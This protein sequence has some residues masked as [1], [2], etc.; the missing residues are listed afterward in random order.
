VSAAVPTKTFCEF[1]AGIGLVAAGLRH[2]G[3]QCVYANDIDP[4]KQE[5]YFAAWG[6]Q[7]YF[8]LADV[9][10]TA[11]IVER[12]PNHPFLAAASFPCTDL[13]LAGMGKGFAGKQSGAFFGFANVLEKLGER[14]PPMV[15]LENVVGFLHASNGGDFRKAA[16]TLAALGYRFDVL[17]IDARFFTPQSRPRVFIVGVHESVLQTVEAA[18]LLETAEF[19]L[20]G[21]ESPFRPSAI[22][23]AVRSVDAT[24]SPFVTFKL[25]AIEEPS[26][27][28]IQLTDKNG[29]WWTA[30]ETDRHWKMLSDKH[31]H[32]LE[33]LRR[34]RKAFIGTAFRRIRNKEQRLE[35]RFDGM[36][37]CL[38]TPRGGSARQI[39]VEIKNGDV[40]MRWMTPTEYARLQGVPDLPLVGSASQQMFGLADAVCVPAVEWLD[41]N[42]LTPVFN[43]AAGGVGKKKRKPKAAK[44]P[45]TAPT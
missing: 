40:R 41:R 14:K 43:A 31:R 36:A 37:G 32:Q 9:A 15:M 13:S 24:P 44:K 8:H 3:W 20:G 18:G 17:L 12:I 34:R 2:S 10:D 22:L 11:A 19:H 27:S 5:Q 42:V 35:V 28:F 1:F 30:K 29:K 38:R 21:E 45:S 25:P 4:K 6:G 39:V 16:A 33:E 23:S 7:Q 26:H